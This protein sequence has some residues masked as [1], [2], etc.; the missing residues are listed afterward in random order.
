MDNID[1]LTEKFKEFPGIGGRQ[2]KRFVYFLLHK[3]PSFVKSLGDEILKLKNNILQCPSCFVFF[4][5]SNNTLCEICRNE[6]TD[7]STLLVI[8][9][10]ADCESFKKANIYKGMYFVIGGLVPIVTKDTPKFVRIE[11]LVNTIQNKI[12]SK[13][14]KEII[15]A[16]ALSPQGDYTDTYIR[17]RLSKIPGI[18]T[19]KITSLGR[20]LSTGSELEYADNETLKNALKNRG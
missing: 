14:L 13:K 7:Q 5:K 9:K 16:L 12:N 15:I 18:D 8:E 2:A 17:E 10:D 4:Q 19:I 6:N 20:G 11:E 1:T 3:N